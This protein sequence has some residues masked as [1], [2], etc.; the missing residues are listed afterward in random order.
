M[1]AISSFF[2]SLLSSHCTWFYVTPGHSHRLE[3]SSLSLLLNVMCDFV[4]NVLSV[5]YD[6][7]FLSAHGL[8]CIFSLPGLYFRKNTLFFFFHKHSAMSSV[9]SL[10]L[11]RIIVITFSYTLPYEKSEAI[12]MS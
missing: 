12:S 10:Y 8:P 6:L 7:S 11:V 4:V 5:A 9:Y 2:F 3:Q 1:H